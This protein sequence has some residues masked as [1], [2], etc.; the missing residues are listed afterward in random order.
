M[1]QK[2]DT[3][4]VV[5]CRGGILYIEGWGGIPFVGNYKVSKC[6]GFLVSKFQSFNVRKLQSF[7][8]SRIN[9]L[10]LTKKQKDNSDFQNAWTPSSK[11][12]NYQF[13]QNTFLEFGLFVLGLFGVSW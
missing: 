10:K 11:P 9:K 7:K 1:F 12:N 6:L 13:F 3:A 5:W 2:N 8:A 4:R